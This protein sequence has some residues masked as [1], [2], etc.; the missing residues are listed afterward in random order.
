MKYI[1]AKLDYHKNV[2]RRETIRMPMVYIGIQ[3][4][5]SSDYVQGR[6]LKTSLD[7]TRVNRDVQIYVR[8]GYSKTASHAWIGMTDRWPLVMNRSVIIPDL[9]R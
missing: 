5:D 4:D 1:F 9:D 7:I 8:M 3:R 6:E 2:Y